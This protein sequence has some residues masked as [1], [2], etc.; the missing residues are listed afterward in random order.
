[1]TTY[2]LMM[3]INAPRESRLSESVK[4]IRLTKESQLCLSKRLSDDE[5][6]AG[7]QNMRRVEVWTESR[8]RGLWGNIFYLRTRGR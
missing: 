4:S 5:P 1:M 3:V 6:L 7:R 8:C 2:L